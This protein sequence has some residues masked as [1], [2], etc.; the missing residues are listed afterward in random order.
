VSV[1]L[2]RHEP[3]ARHPDEPRGLHPL[4]DPGEG[5]EFLAGPGLEDPATDLR[6]DLVTGAEQLYQVPGVGHAD[7]A[8]LSKLA[9]PAEP[10]HE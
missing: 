2:H 7:P 5:R 10:G 6:V 1:L 8:G 4:H 3:G 9:A